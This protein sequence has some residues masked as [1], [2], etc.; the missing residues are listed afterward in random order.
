[1]IGGRAVLARSSMLVGLYVRFVEPP[2]TN[3]PLLLLLLLLLL[4]CVDVKYNYYVDVNVHL[5]L[6]IFRN[7]FELL[8]VCV[9]VCSRY[10][11][12]PYFLSFSLVN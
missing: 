2:E 7:I 5:V 10:A 6:K 3:P 11:G 9:C 12:L 8:I 1:M 4:L